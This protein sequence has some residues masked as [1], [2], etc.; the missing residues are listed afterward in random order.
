MDNKDEA[1]KLTYA[2]LFTF[3]KCLTVYIV[4]ESQQLS[5]DD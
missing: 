4:E 5:K 2:L 3:P 1:Q